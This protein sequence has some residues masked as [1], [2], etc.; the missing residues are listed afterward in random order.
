MS[1]Y[2]LSRK[3][4]ILCKY[5]SNINLIDTFKWS[6]GGLKDMDRVFADLYCGKNLFIDGSLKWGDLYS[7]NK[8]ILFQNCHFLF[9][10]AFQE[11]PQEKLKLI[12]IKEMIEMEFTEVKSNMNEGL[13][14]LPSLFLFK[15]LLILDSSGQLPF[16]LIYKNVNKAFNNYI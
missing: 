7:W 11:F 16:Q 15:L 4:S 6:Y 13:I 10:F 2:L 9:I 5:T 12:R 8:H 14:L 3:K 1:Y